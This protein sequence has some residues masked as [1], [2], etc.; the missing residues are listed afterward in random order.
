MELI[1]ILKVRDPKET[2]ARTQLNNLS[3]VIDM[4]AYGN[5]KDYFVRGIDCAYQNLKNMTT[6]WSKC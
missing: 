6:R 3:N 1:R 2:T 4:R 5:L